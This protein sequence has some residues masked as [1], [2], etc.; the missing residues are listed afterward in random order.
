[1]YDANMPQPKHP[2][3]KR[4]HAEKA[5]EARVKSAQDVAA[6]VIAKADRKGSHATRN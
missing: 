1:M 5:A 3:L 2:R 4:D 6:L